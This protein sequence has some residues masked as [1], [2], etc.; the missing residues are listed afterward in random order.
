MGLIKIIMFNLLKS[1]KTLFF[2]SIH[3]IVF[4]MYINLLRYHL[5]LYIDEETL[6]LYTNTAVRQN[7]FSYYGIGLYL[8]TGGILLYAFMLIDLFIY[9]RHND[10]KG[11]LLTHIVNPISRTGY[12]VRVIA[13]VYFSYILLIIINLCFSFIIIT[14][15][16]QLFNIKF[17]I[18]G[19]AALLYISLYSLVICLLF[20]LVCLVIRYNELSII[21]CSLVMIFSNFSYF[22][23]LLTVHIRI[24]PVLSALINLNSDLY[25]FFINRFQIFKDYTHPIYEYL[26]MSS[27]Y[28]IDPDLNLIP[29]ADI[30]ILERN[31]LSAFVITIIVIIVLILL[32]IKRFKMLDIAGD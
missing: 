11:I 25:L 14:A 2:I 30:N 13:G 5:D 23:K 12:Y 26:S 3:T 9:L 21:I 28:L 15:L 1:K 29:S 20:S 16:F 7:I 17:V 24:G 10:E 22:L 8:I 32:N 27:V 19:F 6:Y 4:Y 18:L 31:E